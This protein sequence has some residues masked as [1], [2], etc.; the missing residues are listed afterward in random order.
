MKKITVDIQDHKTW[1]NQV[2]SA[3]SGISMGITNGDVR[4]DLD[5]FF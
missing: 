5:G 2:L 1:N 3:F 4:W